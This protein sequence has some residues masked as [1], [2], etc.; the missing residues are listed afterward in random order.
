MNSNLPAKSQQEELKHRQEYEKMIEAAKKKE[1][2][3]KELKIKKYQQQ[4]RKEDFMAQ[5]LRLWN[6][7]ILTNWNEQYVYLHSNCSYF[8]TILF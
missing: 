8:L 1:Q 3:E 2:K 7:E 5:S 6:T 4:I